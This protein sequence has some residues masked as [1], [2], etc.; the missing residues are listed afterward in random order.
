MI[1]EYKNTFVSINPTTYMKL[2]WKSSFKYTNYQGSLK[3][4]IQ[5]LICS[6]SI[7]D[8]KSVV[9]YSHKNK[10]NKNPSR[11]SWLCWWVLATIQERNNIDCTPDFLASRKGGNNP[12]SYE[13]SII[14]ISKPYKD[15]TRKEG[16]RLISLWDKNSLTKC[17]PVEC[18]NIENDNA[19]WS[20]G[21]YSM[22]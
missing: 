1:R 12:T 13:A 6:M 14:P 10:T 18:S 7:K 19:S 20:S 3:K 21:F 8:I 17:E 2:K 4:E 22:N 16:Y 9:K 5:S 11:L 15:I